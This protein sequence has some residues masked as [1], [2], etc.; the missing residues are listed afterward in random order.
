M[1]FWLALFTFT[2]SL[3]AS[4]MVW[5]EEATPQVGKNVASNM[6]VFSVVIS[7]LFV[8][9]LIIVVAAILRR[10]Q[11]QG[12]KSAGLKVI[13]SMHLGTKERLVV[14]D[15][16]GKQ[17]LLG[18]TAQQI[19]LLQTLE[20]PLEVGQPLASDISKNIVKLLKSND[21]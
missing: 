15:V 19:T 5:A 7:L 21:K 9:L 3:F 4:S 13:T 2:S 6:D 1:R 11:P 17:L 8:L 14:V 20:T 16:D 12:G 18:V 10:F